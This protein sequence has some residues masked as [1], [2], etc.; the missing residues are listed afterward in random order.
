MSRH[1]EGVVY[2]WEILVPFFFYFGVSGRTGNW[3]F[4]LGGSGRR[5]FGWR[6]VVVGLMLW[7]Q[8]RVCWL[9]KNRKIV[10]CVELLEQ[11]LIVRFCS[12]GVI[13]LIEIVGKER[14]K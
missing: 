13:I 7:L 1:R 10:E 5:L 8:S 6:K 12:G 11:G 2:S 3:A 14:K 9:F 4:S